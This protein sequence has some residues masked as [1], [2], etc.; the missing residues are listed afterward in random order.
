MRQDTSATQWNW[1]V[2]RYV[3]WWR[4]VRRSLKRHPS[5]TDRHSLSKVAKTSLSMYTLS[6]LSNHIDEGHW[7]PNKPISVAYRPEYHFESPL[8]FRYLKLQTLENGETGKLEFNGDGDRMNPMYN[9]INVKK[10]EQQAV[11][12]RYSAAL[13]SLVFQYNDVNSVNTQG[14]V[15]VCGW[16]ASLK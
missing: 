6:L 15:S 12:G 4:L 3:R 11:V 2:K 14:C 10:G 16:K 1:S 8:A 9:V 13:V 7:T 5:A